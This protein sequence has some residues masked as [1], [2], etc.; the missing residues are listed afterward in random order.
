M[1]DWAVVTPG[2]LDHSLVVGKKASL[3]VR[4]G[5]LSN[6]CFSVG[7]F[8]ALHLVHSHTRIINLCYGLSVCVSPNPPIETL[9]SIS[10]SE[11]LHLTR[12][13]ASLVIQMVKNL[14][15]MREIWV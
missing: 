10:R 6:I 12:G 9:A 8:S 13:G 5:L 2:H 14:P 15:A 1:C 11:I 7:H 3:K 4:T